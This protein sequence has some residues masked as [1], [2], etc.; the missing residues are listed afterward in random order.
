MSDDVVPIDATSAP[1]LLAGLLA[2]LA[3][4]PWFFG[5]SGV[6]LVVVSIYFFV[7]IGVDVRYSA[8]KSYWS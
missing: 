7:M 8:A 6:A 5:S 4:M 1:A 2:L 3:L